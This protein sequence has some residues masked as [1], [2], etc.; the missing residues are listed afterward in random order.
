MTGSV[1]LDTFSLVADDEPPGVPEGRRLWLGRVA[2]M[3]MPVVGLVIGIMSLRGADASKIGPY[4]LVQALPMGYY[5]GL[6]LTLLSFPFIWCAR[7]P[8]RLEF[9]LAII[10]QVVLLHGAPAIVE[11]LPRFPSAWLLAG[12]TNFVSD[13]GRVLPLVDARFSWPSMFAGVAILGRAG[14]M[15]SA[16]SLLKWWPVVLDVLCIP[17][18]YLIAKKLLHDPK[19]ALLAVWLFPLANWVGQDY[20][21]PQAVA[22]LLYLV[23]L[24]VVIGP[25]GARVPMLWRKAWVR[26]SRG[27][28]PAPKERTFRQ[29]VVLFTTLLVLTVALATGHQ[30]TPIFA[31]ITILAL[32]LS[33]RTSLR[34]FVFLMGTITLAW[35]CYGAFSFWAGHTSKL[36]GGLGDVGGN[37][38]SSVSSRLGGSHAH[39]IVTRLRLLFAA[40]IWGLATL[41]LILGRRLKSDRLSLAVLMFAPFS[42]LVAQ[43]YGGEGGLRVYLISLPGALCLMAMAVT[44]FRGGPRA[45][46]VMGTSPAFRPGLVHA[47]AVLALTGLMVPLFLISRWG[48]ELYEETRP[49]EMV[50]VE[51]LYKM[52]PPGA[53]LLAMDSHI[54]WRF[55][56]VDRYDYRSTSFTDF[57]TGD[58][59]AIQHHFTS[60]PAGGFLIITTAQIEFGIENYGLPPDW[61]QTLE[62]KLTGTG[63]FK[64]VYENPDA[65]IYRYEGPT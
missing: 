40:G 28:V 21:S 22:F 38:A 60:N 62:A 15:A 53:T 58:I 20:F 57:A 12:F 3:A 61:A 29:I 8:S 42:I 19:R 16:V 44:A 54:P 14:G 6:A 11:T 43:S 2:R 46:D 17:P 27:P 24:C 45:R 31:V 34:A 9:P 23:L 32:S 4:G 64:L 36:F 41:G 10:V 48:N 30:L 25:L 13:Q 47:A 52:A 5:A 55:T 1:A 33:G 65:R 56:D 39:H 63:H 37:V 50:A 51:A 49:N 7:R 59:G 35:I 26:K 18:L